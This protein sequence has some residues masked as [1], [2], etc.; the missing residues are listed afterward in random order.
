MKTKTITETK[1]KKCG[2][3]LTGHN[4]IETSNGDYYCSFSCLFDD[5]EAQV[6][7]KGGK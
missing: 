7:H 5:N 6:N 1:C 4:R 3:S 2:K